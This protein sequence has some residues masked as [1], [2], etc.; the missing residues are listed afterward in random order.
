MDLVTW[1]GKILNSSASEMNLSSEKSIKFRIELLVCWC[2]IGTSN[3]TMW[4]RA[5]PL[6]SPDGLNGPDLLQICT[7]F[8]MLNVYLPI[9]NS[10][11]VLAT[12]RKRM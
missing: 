9:Y 12:C 4:T 6:P 2:K 1:C 5:P 8:S 10:V 3:T 11:H 7:E